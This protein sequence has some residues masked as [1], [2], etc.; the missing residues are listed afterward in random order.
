MVKVINPRGRATV[1]GTSVI[2]KGYPVS[3]VFKIGVYAVDDALIIMPMREAQ[4]F[5]G[6]RRKVQRPKSQKVSLI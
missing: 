3:A 2:Q 6:A 1:A 5:F 4:L